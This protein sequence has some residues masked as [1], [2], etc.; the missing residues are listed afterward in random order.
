MTTE[1]AAVRYTSKTGMMM[2]YIL[3]VADPSGPLHPAAGGNSPS[4]T[5]DKIGT[6]RAT[7]EEL[8]LGHVRLNLEKY[9]LILQQYYGTVHVTI[10]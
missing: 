10:L 9:S 2:Y 7:E 6:S 3:C 8:Y 1:A 4:G 5:A